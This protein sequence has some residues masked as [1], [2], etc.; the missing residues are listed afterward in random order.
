M[1]SQLLHVNDIEIRNC[2][3]IAI[4]HLACDVENRAPVVTTR[5]RQTESA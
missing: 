3:A 4:C 1:P 5:R 2:G